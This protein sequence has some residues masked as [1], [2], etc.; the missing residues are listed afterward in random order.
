MYDIKLIKCP[1]CGKDF[2]YNSSS[3]YKLVIHGEL[4]WYCSYT[5]YRSVQKELYKKSRNRT[6]YHNK[7]GGLDDVE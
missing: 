3:I 2:V 4:F 7:Y 5:C 6:S 1:V